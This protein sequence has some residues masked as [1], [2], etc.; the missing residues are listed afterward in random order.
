MADGISITDLEQ[1]AEVTDN[2][3]FA[4]DNGAITNKVTAKQ[5]KDYMGPTYVKKSGDTMSGPLKAPTPDFSSDDTT[6]VNR[7]WASKKFSRVVSNCITKIPQDIKLELSTDGTLTL[8]AG[9]KVYDGA[10]NVVNITSDKTI[11]S[12]TNGES[13]ALLTSSG[14]TLTSIEVK[15]C[16]SGETDSMAGQQYHLWYDTTNKVVNYYG[17]NGSVASNTITLPI[18]LI[19]VA[20]GKITSIDQVFNGFGYIGSAV[21][22]LPGVEGLVA[23]GRNADG[24]LKN[25]S[26]KLNNLFV[27]QNN[28][29][30]YDAVVAIAQNSLT[31]YT[32]GIENVDALPENPVNLK[33]YYV[34]PENKIYSWNGTSF[35]LENSVPCA[36]I[37]SNPQ[38]TITSFEV[39]NVFKSVDFNDFYE[40]QKLSKNTVNLVQNY[41]IGF[42]N[43][44]AKVSINSG[45]T[46]PSNGWVLIISSNSSGNTEMKF[47]DQ[48]V[49]FQGGQGSAASAA[50]GLV[51]IRK[52]Q[53]VTITGVTSVKQF[54]PML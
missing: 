48:Q 39:R 13:F 6:V 3:N 9:S 17:Q 22:G 46:A 5:I 19:T 44:S 16:T 21:F 50:C 37:S 30:V 32:M 12:S 14:A 23:N 26:V 36:V 28:G 8:K 29:N 47:D 40:I 54:M 41:R 25:A 1:K 45:Y 4:V 11:T 43:L 24:S 42:P 52:G 31:R 51:P 53:V 18:A 20:D 38:S 10:G 35:V 33:R 34:I 7:E 15:R 27:Y 49:Y 2:D